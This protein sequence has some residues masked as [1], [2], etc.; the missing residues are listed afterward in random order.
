M[1]SF[2]Y[3]NLIQ[4]MKVLKFSVLITISSA[5][6]LVP[7]FRVRADIFS[8]LDRIN[9]DINGTKGKIDNAGSTINGLG[10][11]LGVGNNNGSG[12]PSTQVLYVYAD[13]YKT[14]SPLDKEVVNMLTTEYAE[15][16]SLDFA[17]FKATNFYRIKNTQDKQ[18]ISGIFF[19]FNEVI[20]VAPKDKFLAFAFCIN[21]G[22]TNCK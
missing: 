19:K 17:G 22:S 12:D 10:K 20:K 13:W 14:M 21:G 4:T 5:L 6:L 7:S 15:K 8:D 3:Q 18:R 2:N 1:L 16:G 9:Q 11:L